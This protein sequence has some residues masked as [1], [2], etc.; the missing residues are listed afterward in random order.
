MT[1]PRPEWPAWLPYV[2]WVS[3]STAEAF[4]LGLPTRT[5]WRIFIIEW[6]GVGLTLTAKPE[7]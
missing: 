2:G 7:E 5:R 4:E 1:G 6:F 3:A